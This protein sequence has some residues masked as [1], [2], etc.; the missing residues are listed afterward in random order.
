M[1]PGE[2]LVWPSE[3]P[4]RLPGVGHETNP[5][6]VIARRLVR[7]L[8]CIAIGWLFGWAI[9]AWVTNDPVPECETEG[10]CLDT[11]TG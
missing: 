1:I 7:L 5:A 2:P 9:G 8:A 3:R 10:T 11:P 6:H 4:L